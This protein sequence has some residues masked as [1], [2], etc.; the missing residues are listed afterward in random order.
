MAILIDK[1]IAENLITQE[2]LSDAKDKQVG[3]KK[4]VIDLLVDMGFLKEEELMRVSSEVFGMP[5][6]KLENEQIDPAAVKLVPYETAKRHGVLPLR[7]DDGKLV[8]ATSN[9]QDVIA[10]DDIRIITRMPVE[11]VLSTR[12]EISKAI[13]ESYQSDETLYDL[14]KNIVDDTKVEVISEKVQG[15]THA[16]MGDL[17]VDNSPVVR[18]VNLILGDALKARASDIHIEPQ[19]EFTEVRYRIDGD[20]KN[21]MKIPNKLHPGVVVRIKIMTDLKISE[22]RKSQD[23]RARISI[24]GNKADLRASVIPTFYGEKIVLRILDTKEAQHGLDNIGFTSGELGIF[25]SEIERP[26]GMVLVTGP[27]GSGKTSTLYAALSRIKNETKNIVTIED[28][29][30]YLV[31]G[32]NQIQV[33]P[34][35]DVTFATG[36]RSILRQDPNVILV[37]EIRDKDTADIAFRASL[38]GHLVFS[39]LHTNNSV[40]TITRLKDIGLETYLISSSIILVI[41]QRLIKVICPHC[42][43]K[44]LPD[45]K[46]TDKF[47]TYIDKYNITEFY[48]GAGCEKCGYSGFM[49]RTAIFE[50]LKFNEKIKAMIIEGAVEDAVFKEAREAGMRP[51]AEAG[52]EKVAEGLVTLE[53]IAKVADVQVEEDKVPEEAPAEKEEEVPEEEKR[54]KMRVLIADDEPDIRL[55]LKKRL[56]QAGYEVI[57]AKDGKEEVEMA[58]KKKPDLIITDIMMPEMD[59]F[60]ATKALRSSLETAVIPIIMLTAKQDKNSELEGIDAGADDYITK[61]FDKDKLL[62]RVKMLLRRRER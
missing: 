59:G 61:P 47:S 18:L 27:T 13:E 8:I 38:T 48:H 34:L 42:K 15:D 53:E 29:I 54:D 37:G 6:K 41:A 60:E 57:S 35:K 39:T 62:A 7:Q 49:G 19:E 17:R 33:N 24:G 55:V 44:Y 3:A 20:L 36:L 4:P 5:V 23:G 50:M 9:P 30:E 21:I 43:E 31:D 1:L 28:P 32:I 2:Q 45:V 11:S 25:L 58:V 40:A 12:G 26:Q 22:T 56:E 51:L 46:M 52:M 10:L 14:L 16:D